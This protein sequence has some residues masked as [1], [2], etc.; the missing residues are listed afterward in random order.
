MI[1]K[2]KKEMVKENELSKSILKDKIK[3]SDGT[4][5]DQSFLNDKTMERCLKICL[6]LRLISLIIVKMFQG[7]L[8]TIILYKKS[9]P[10]L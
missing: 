7:F 1:L 5:K 10:D 9:K 4:L 3:L 6:G 2:T 8:L